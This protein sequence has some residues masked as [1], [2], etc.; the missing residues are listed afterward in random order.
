MKQLLFL[1]LPFAVASCDYYNKD[2]IQTYFQTREVEVTVNQSGDV[3]SAVGAF[4]GAFGDGF[5][6]TPINSENPASYWGEGQVNPNSNYQ[7]YEP[8]KSTPYYM[9]AD[10]NGQYGGG[11]GSY[12]GH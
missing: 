5:Q 6:Y 9:G 11:I 10:E 7:P 4:G 2:N 1:L 12:Y 3:N 8:G